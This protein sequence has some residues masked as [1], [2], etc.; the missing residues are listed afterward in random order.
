MYFFGY[1]LG[2]GSELAALKELIGGNDSALALY[3]QFHDPESSLGNKKYS[4]M[5]VGPSSPLAFSGVP[6][7]FNSL[8]FPE[9]FLSKNGAGGNAA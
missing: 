4:F 3:Q 7:F 2:W 1:G 6:L 8:Q 5:S 9:E